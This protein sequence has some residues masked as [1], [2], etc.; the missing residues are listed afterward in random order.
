LSYAKQFSGLSEDLVKHA[1]EGEPSFT[2]SGY[3]L[4][5]YTPE[6]IGISIQATILIVGIAIGFIISKLKVD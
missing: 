5:P 6:G 4:V 3:S 2:S 1:I